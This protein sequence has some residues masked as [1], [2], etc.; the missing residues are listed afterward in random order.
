MLKRFLL[1]MVAITA[2]ACSQDSAGPASPVPGDWTIDISAATE[3]WSC[4]LQGGTL[5]IPGDDSPHDGELTP[6]TGGCSGGY[7]WP[8][9]LFAWVWQDGVFITIQLNPEGGPRWLVLKGRIDGDRMSGQVADI[10]CR[11]NDYGCETVAF[12]GSWSATR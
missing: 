6:G 4:E 10:Q 8:P 11:Q 12:D 5:A 2:T 9:E 3:T 7:P 1:S